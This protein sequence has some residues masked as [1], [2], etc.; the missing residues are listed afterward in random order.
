MIRL[1]TRDLT[2]QFHGVPILRGLTLDFKQGETVTF[3]GPSGSGKSTY[4]RCLNLLEIPDGGSLCWD[5]QE[6]NYH[7]FSAQQLSQ[8][9]R[10]LGMVFQ[11]FNL[12]PHLS[13]LGNVME[14]P[15]HVLQEPPDEAHERAVELL[16][17]VGL[18]K[19]LNHWPAQL[20]GGQ[21][22]RIAIARAL[23]MRPEALLLDEVTSAL[24]VEA[25]A[26]INTLLS[27]LAESTTMVAV[28]HDLHFARTI[29]QR[30]VLLEH[31]QVVEQGPP[32]QV[33]GQPT[34]ER[35]QEFLARSSGAHA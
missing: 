28:T 9:R 2:K 19:H 6:L 8:H 4:L 14:G 29:S 17:R 30:V 26:E 13:A 11:Q 27:Q 15:V 1:S 33:L 21:K 12:F 5:G 16:R 32:E 10:R 23:A 7:N 20:S 35:A 24:D 31:G 22:Q 3:V 34:T 18:E 25:S